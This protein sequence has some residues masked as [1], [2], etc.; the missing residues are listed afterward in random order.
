MNI[1]N[2]GL[3][4]RYAVIGIDRQDAVHALK[5][6]DDSAFHRHGAPAQAGARTPRDKGNSV[7]ICDANDLR[8]LFG[9]LWKNNDVGPV[10]EKGEGVAFVDEEVGFVVSNAGSAEDLP[11][12]GDDFFLHFWFSCSL[13]TRICSFTMLIS[14]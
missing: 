9:G 5:L 10:L 14:G 13:T 3:K 2:A 7:F 4:N 12:S 6:D 1:H 8:D 11:K